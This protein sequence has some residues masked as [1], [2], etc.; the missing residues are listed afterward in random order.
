MLREERKR[1]APCVSGG[2]LV[3]AAGTISHKTVSRPGIDHG[4]WMVGD[5]LFDLIGRDVL[6]AVSEEKESWASGL[7]E[8]R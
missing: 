6:V 1:P 8:L 2:R 5:D 4:F 7:A 3:K